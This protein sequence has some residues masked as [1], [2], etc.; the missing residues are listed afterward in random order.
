MDFVALWKAASIV[1]TG[2]FGVLALLTEYRDKQTNKVTKWG[3][4]SLVGIL[5]SAGFGVAAQL[6]ENSQQETARE[7]VAKQT[8]TLLEN[9]G[10]AVGDIQRILSSIDDPAISIQIKIPC[11]DA[12]FVKFCQLPAVILLGHSI[13]EKLRPK[14]DLALGFCFIKEASATNRAAEE[15]SHDCDLSLFASLSESASRGTFEL[16]R[17]K[18]GLVIDIWAKTSVSQNT[19]KIVSL[20]DMYGSTVEVFGFRDGWT[21]GRFK[22]RTR[23]AQEVSFEPQF[24]PIKDTTGYRAVVPASKS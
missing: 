17:T 13:P 16:T 20:R 18:H 10:R 23:S 9:T 21:P 19:G 4:I 8:L 7:T 14:F 6:I 2:I 24:S 22:V 12:E 1:V 5:V 15:L 3:Y 11:T